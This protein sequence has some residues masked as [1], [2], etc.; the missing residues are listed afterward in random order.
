MPA[1]RCSPLSGPAQGDSALGADPA[2]YP[3]C[4]ATDTRLNAA[5]RY[6]DQPISRTVWGLKTNKSAPIQYG[7]ESSMYL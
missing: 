6:N 2:E 3:G 4:P 5:A 1:G 7:L